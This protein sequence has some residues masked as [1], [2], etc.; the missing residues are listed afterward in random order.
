VRLA[1]RRLLSWLRREPVACRQCSAE[2]AVEWRRFAYCPTCLVEDLI[3]RHRPE[4]TRLMAKRTR[5][6]RAGA[7]TASLDAQLIR[8][9]VRIQQDADQFPPVIA[10][11]VPA[12]VQRWIEAA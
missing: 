7:R 2:L 3:E 10:A 5:Y 1:I 11:A 6:L 12:A 9:I 4:F 8:R